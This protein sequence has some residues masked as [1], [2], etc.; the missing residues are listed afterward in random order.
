MA[1][2]HLVWDAGLSFEDLGEQPVPQLPKL[3]K[4]RALAMRYGKQGGYT[5]GD[6]YVLYLGEKDLPVA[7]AFHK[8]GAKEPSLVTTWEDYVTRGGLTLPTRFKTPDGTTVIRIVDLRVETAKKAAPPASR[9]TSRP[10][11]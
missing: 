2:L 10:G 3:G 11:R 1:T 6:H 7:W 8:A 9:P 5:P 4:R